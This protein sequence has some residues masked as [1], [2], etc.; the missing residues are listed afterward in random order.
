MTES[1]HPS[2]TVSNMRMIAAIIIGLI[3]EGAVLSIYG[4]PIIEV[5]TPAPADVTVTAP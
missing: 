1:N 4:D 5:T 3:V 2:S